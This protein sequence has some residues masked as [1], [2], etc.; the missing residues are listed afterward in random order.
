M[1]ANVVPLLELC[2]WID[3]VDP[4]NV[5]VTGVA[6]HTVDVVG[7][8]LPAAVVGLTVTTAV[9]VVVAVVQTPLV[10]SALK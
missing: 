6:K 3:P 1:L 9:A 2:H 5:K 7:V 4:P 8:I 10:T